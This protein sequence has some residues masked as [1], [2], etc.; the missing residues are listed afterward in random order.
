MTETGPVDIITIVRLRS[1]AKE[2][3]DGQEYEYRIR[4]FKNLAYLHD[5]DNKSLRRLFRGCSVHTSECAAGNFKTDLVIG[6]LRN[7]VKYNYD[8]ID[9][10]D[11]EEFYD[12]K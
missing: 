12:D 3:A 9:M 11:N 6:F 1:R 8:T 5:N 10:R 4:A 7:S 2:N